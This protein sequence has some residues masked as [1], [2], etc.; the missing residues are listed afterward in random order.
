[1]SFPHCRANGRLRPAARRIFRR[2]AGVLAI[3]LSVTVLALVAPAH[4]TVTDVPD[5]EITSSV[6]LPAPGQQEVLPA[7]EAPVRP[8][9]YL[10]FNVSWGIISGGSAYLEVPEVREYEGHKVYRLLARAESNAFISRIYKVR[11][12]IESFWD[13]DAHYS[14]RYF[15]DR[16]EGKYKK[17]EEILF[18][19]ARQMATY[20]NGE[21]FP[22]PPRVQDALSSFY[23]TRFQALPM[24]G[25]IVFDYHASKKS[26][27]L[28]V[29]IIGRERVKVP[30]G[31]FDCIVV[32]PLLKAGGVFKKNGRLVIWLT[33]DERRMPVLMKS[34][35]TIGSVSVKLE[36]YRTGNG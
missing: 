32:E 13:E 12:V 18:D 23:Y 3:L 15:E 30:A 20:D 34:K 2:S 6:L 4:T 7:L 1:M 29:K 24:G 31:E 17:R 26:K 36:E 27:P 33:D 19:Q 25:S 35:V 16:K 28:E 9:E 21:I 5:E 8:G 11:N 14:R 10:K 22:V